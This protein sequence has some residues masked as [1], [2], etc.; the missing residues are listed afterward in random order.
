MSPLRVQLLLIATMA[1]WGLNITAIK[2]LTAEMHPLLISSFRMVLASVVIH[3]TLAH[4]QRRLKLRRITPA[5]WLRF[6]ICSIFMVYGNQVF[7]TGGMVTASA[8]NTSLIMALGPLV[9]SVLAAFIF[10]E[11]LTGLRILG[12]I[13]GFG[14]V[15]AVIFSNPSAALSDAGWGDLQIFG[16]MLSFVAGGMLIQAMAR[17]F[18]AL[19]ISAIIYTL[20][21]V[22]LCLH[23]AISP[24]VRLD[25]ESLLI[26]WW[27]WILLIF[28]GI[29]ATAIGNMIWNWAITELG[30]ARTTLFQYWIPV[31]GVGFAL[32]LLGEA[33]TV[34]HAIGLLGILLGTYFGTKRV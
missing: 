2:V 3:M 24:S 21:S 9:A 4:Y 23:V 16:A 30:A 13:L 26:G 12:I 19:T 11:S 22:F 33:F 34:W 1:I 17:Q 20:G 10:R 7:F 14:G 32:L 6:V 29:I 5:Q 15:F 27:P 31:F 28:S 18:D 25:A 8:T